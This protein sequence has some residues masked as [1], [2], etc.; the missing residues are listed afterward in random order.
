MFEQESTQLAFAN[1]VLHQAGVIAADVASAAPRPNCLRIADH[2]HRISDLTHGHQPF[3]DNAGQ[4]EQLE[5][6]RN[7]LITVRRTLSVATHATDIRRQKRTM[8]RICNNWSSRGEPSHPQFTVPHDG[9]GNPRFGLPE[10][11]RYVR[12]RGT[13]ALLSAYKDP[14]AVTR[15]PWC[16]SHTA[17]SRRVDSLIRS[18][19]LIEITACCRLSPA[20]PQESVFGA[21]RKQARR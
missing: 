21:K 5:G 15:A 10:Y 13:C 14:D 18:H 16:I 20:P 19:S 6:G 9:Q 11:L 17:F 7:Q 2:R 8:V 4:G 12:P 1:Q 3:G